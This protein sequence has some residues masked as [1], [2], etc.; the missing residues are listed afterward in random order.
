[1]KCNSMENKQITLDEMI[2]ECELELLKKENE[3]S[4]KEREEDCSCKK[5]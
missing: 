3:D 5:F 4:N 1:M 2:R